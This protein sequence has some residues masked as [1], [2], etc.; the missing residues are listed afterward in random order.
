MEKPTP[1]NLLTRWICQALALDLLE[2][3]RGNRTNQTVR[4]F[5][6]NANCGQSWT[7]LFTNII[8]RFDGV[9]ANKI[10]WVVQGIRQC[11]YGDL[12]LKPE[13]AESFRRVAC[14]GRVLVLKALGQ[15]RNSKNCIRTEALEGSDCGATGH[16][17]FVGDNGNKCRRGRRADASKGMSRSSRALIAARAIGDVRKVWD[18]G[19]GH[20]TKYVKCSN[21][22]ICPSGVSFLRKPRPN[23]PRISSKGHAPNNRS[24]EHLGPRGLWIIGNPMQEKRQGIRADVLN[25]RFSLSVPSPFGFSG[26]LSPL[27]PA[28]S[29][30][31]IAE[32]KPSVA[33][34][35]TAVDQDCRNNG[36]RDANAH[37]NF[38]PTPHARSMATPQKEWNPERTVRRPDPTFDFLSC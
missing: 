15:Y 14:D 8:N 30:N 19:S 21:R 12:W 23:A 7:C 34:L 11:S 1:S 38:F 18:D 35:G 5:E 9:E 27:L 16:G 32:R 24:N 37:E 17:S 2:D 29:I 25:C 13:M 26:M 28:E 36:K 3:I 22:G 33:R 6:C 10:P 20:W 31:P 4:I